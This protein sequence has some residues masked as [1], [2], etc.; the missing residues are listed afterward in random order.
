MCMSLSS[1]YRLLKKETGRSLIDLQHHIRIKHA[2]ELLKTTTDSATGVGFTVG[3]ET[4]KSFFSTFKQI[5]G[6]TPKEFRNR[7]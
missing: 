6:V 5:V 4:Q 1:L 7:E 3:F 2:M